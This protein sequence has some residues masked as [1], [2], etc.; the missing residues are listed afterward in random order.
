MASEI[1]DFLTNLTPS[2][3]GLSSTIMVF[4]K[5][6]KNLISLYVSMFKV[7]VLS[8]SSIYLYYLLFIK[9]QVMRESSVK[10][11][12]IITIFTLVFSIISAFILYGQVKV[13]SKLKSIGNKLVSEVDNNQ[14]TSSSNIKEEVI[15]KEKTN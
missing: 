4:Y 2:L 9:K 6:E 7:F 10:I 3:L 14:L 13:A 5:N 1:L 8:I 11:S 12:F 15:G